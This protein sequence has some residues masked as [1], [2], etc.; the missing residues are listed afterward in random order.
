MTEKISAIVLDITRHN[1]RMNV[2]TLYSRSRGRLSFLSPIGSGKSRQMRQARLQPLAVI[3]SDIN[4]KA[5]AELQR[6]GSFSFLT[7]WHDIYF[8]PVKQIMALFLSEFLNK[9]LRAT[10]PDENLWD[11]IFN[12]LRL[13]DNTSEGISNFHIAFLSSLLPFVGIQPDNSGYRYG[14]CFDMQSGTFKSDPAFQSNLADHAAIKD[15]GF[16]ISEKPPFADQDT[17]GNDN[18]STILSGGEAYMAAMLCR[19]NFSNVGALRLDRKQRY[20]ILHRLLQ[21][22]S[23]HFPGSGNLKSLDII[24][25]IFR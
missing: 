5:T 7:V 4:F 11:Y 21:Y 8:N 10:M 9:L 19:I 25:E 3:E 12:S 22:Y 6:L 17:L 23:I 14:Y 20:K 1:D 24:H 18:N 2:I 15:Q 16:K 13:L